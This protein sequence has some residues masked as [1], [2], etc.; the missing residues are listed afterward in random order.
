MTPKQ[1]AWPKKRVNYFIYENKWPT[2][3]EWLALGLAS[4]PEPRNEA[5]KFHS[6]GTETAY[7]I[8]SDIRTAEVTKLKEMLSVVKQNLLHAKSRLNLTKETDLGALGLYEY[9][10]EAI[11]RI[12]DSE[13]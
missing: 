2:R 6:I 13:K 12:E 11:K 9:I 4:M 5:Q 10:R 1:E 7:D 8:L 3:E